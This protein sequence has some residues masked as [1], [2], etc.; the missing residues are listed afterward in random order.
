M[1]KDIGNGKKLANDAVFEK[2]SFDW[3][4]VSSDVDLWLSENKLHGIWEPEQSTLI[5]DQGIPSKPFENIGFGNIMEEKDSKKFVGL[6][7]ADVLVVITG[8]YISKLASAV[9]YDK[10]EPEKLS[11]LVQN[12]LY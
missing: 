6:Q 3:E 10:S 8:S 12:G 1:I 4:K 5:L 7:L 11:T 2:V 9:R